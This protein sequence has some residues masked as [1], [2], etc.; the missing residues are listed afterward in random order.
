M[1]RAKAVGG[2]GEQDPEKEEKEK[3]RK[4][5]RLGRGS[6]GDVYRIGVGETIEALPPSVNHIKAI[7]G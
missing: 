6:T 4:K 1:T 3:K 2:L 7:N 5:K